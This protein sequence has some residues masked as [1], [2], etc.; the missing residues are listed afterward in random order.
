MRKQILFISHKQS[1][2]HLK[3]IQFTI[4][5]Q[6]Y[7]INDSVGYLSEKKYIFNNGKNNTVIYIYIYIYIYSTI[8]IIFY[9][10]VRVITYWKF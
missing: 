5:Q 8:K 9:D 7:I 6:N 4:V 3:W 2:L 1:Y 10:P